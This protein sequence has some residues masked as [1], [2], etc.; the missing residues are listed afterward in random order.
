[1]KKITEVLAKG[2]MK[3]LFVT[4]EE[5]PFAKVGGLGEVMFSLPRALRK[6]G[7]D[8]RVMMPLYGDIDQKKYKMSY[9]MKGLEVPTVPTG[10]KGAKLVCNVRFF[11]PKDQGRDPV[12]TYLLENQEYYELRSNVY[13]Y[14]DD[15]IRFALL[16]RA[17]LEFLDA[18]R[19]W[20]PD[21]IVATDWMTGYLPNFLKND[22]KDN[23]YLQTIATVFSI[24]NMKVQGTQQ[25]VRFTP[26]AERDD[27]YGAIP[28]L[29]DARLNDTNSVKRA[30]INAEAV[31][32]V[33]A[34]Y[35]AEITTEEYGEGLE[36]LLR[37]QRAK[38]CGILNGIDY[39]TNDP[40]TDRLLAER[41]SARHI[42]GRVR[43]KLELQRRLGLKSDEKAFCMGIVSRIN[44]QKGFAL[45]KPIIEP[46]LRAT[47]AQLAVVGTGD[48]ELMDFFVALEKSYPGQV[49]AFMQYDDALPHLVFS[50]CDVLLIPSKFEPSGLTQME[51]MRYGTVPVARRTGGLADTIEDYAPGNR[52]T[53][54][55]FADMDAQQLLIALTRAFAHWQDRAEWKALQQR[56]MN[57]DFSWDKSAREY[58]GLFRKVIAARRSS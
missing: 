14:S 54:F 15:R 49:A 22:Y 1:M 18:Q 8:A 46:F 17:C 10:E 52:G 56:V 48:P 13:G 35:A 29:F 32:T 2:K 34:T 45:L 40:S 42:E 25:P 43:N 12:K 4:A 44:S 30:I 36:N 39:E 53:G 20:K 31:N 38:L 41:Y 3:I 57:K 28:A 11:E 6:L 37:E 51:A 27:G 55:L 50:G 26:E 47:G 7:H 19:S 9:V 21:I 58:A 5:A 23:E 24:H 16:S 33:S